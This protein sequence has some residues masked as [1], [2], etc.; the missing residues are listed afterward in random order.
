MENKALI[1]TRHIGYREYEPDV[2]SQKQKCLDYARRHNYEIVG[3]YSDSPDDKLTVYPMFEEMKKAIKKV[4]VNKILIK[5]TSM[6]GRNFNKTFNWLISLKRK[7]IDVIFVDQED[8][9]FN[10]FF[11]FTIEYF[12]NKG[13]IK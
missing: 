1:Y 5:S 9:F 13:K 6:L 7:G 10:S 12:I 2:E 4:K 8:S 3:I 11:D